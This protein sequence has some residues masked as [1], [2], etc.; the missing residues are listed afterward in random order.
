[1]DWAPSVGARLLHLLNS[2]HHAAHHALAAPGPPRVH[3]SA[4]GGPGR[5]AA[6]VHHHLS[7]A[8]LGPLQQLPDGGC[9]TCLCAFGHARAHMHT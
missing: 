7:P 8:R 9:R 5:G 2:A 1:M 6:Q 4:C 3:A